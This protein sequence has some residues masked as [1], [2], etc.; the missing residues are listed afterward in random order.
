MK[1]KWKE[2]DSVKDW[3]DW[4]AASALSIFRP[5]VYNLALLD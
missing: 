2:S 4:D 3:A 1:R 5:G